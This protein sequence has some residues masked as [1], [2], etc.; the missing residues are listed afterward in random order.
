MAELSFLLDN[1]DPNLLGEL[2]VANDKFD[3]I[4]EIISYRNKKHDEYQLLYEEGKV[5]ERLEAQLVDFTD[6]LYDQLPDTL[7]FLYS[8]LGK[9]DCDLPQ[10]GHIFCRII[11]RTIWGCF[12]SFAKLK[13]SFGE[14]TA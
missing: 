9:L 8:V 14:E 13:W 10:Y 2:V 12:W 5:S 3:T 11:G 6:A 4:C 1:V 7:L